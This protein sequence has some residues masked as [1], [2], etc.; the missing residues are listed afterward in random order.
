MVISLTGSGL[1]VALPPPGHSP[2]L[3]A[4]LVTGR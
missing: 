2:V 4:P 3:V 1:Q